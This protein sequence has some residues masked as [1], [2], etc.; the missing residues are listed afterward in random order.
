MVEAAGV[1]VSSVY[2]EGGGDDLSGY[3]LGR[4]SLVT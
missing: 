1:S 2:P 3:R 4:E